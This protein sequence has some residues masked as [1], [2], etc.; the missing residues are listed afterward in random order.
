MLN[1][2][3]ERQ[4]DDESHNDNQDVDESDEGDDSDSNNDSDDNED[5][6]E[7][8]DNND[9]HDLDQSDDSND[10]DYN[11]DNDGLDPAVPNEIYD[12][13]YK[14][15]YLPYQSQ[16]FERELVKKI[17]MNCKNLNS[18]K[19]VIIKLHIIW[20]FFTTTNIE[21]FLITFYVKTNK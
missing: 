9:N 3:K 8:K 11:D 1:S 15:V 6:D 17:E 19:Q 10:S 13:P 20:A 21:T 4:F 2:N 7:S 18:W 5:N 14:I 12:K 16:T